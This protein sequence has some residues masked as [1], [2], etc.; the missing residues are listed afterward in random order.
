MEKPENGRRKTVS[1]RLKYEELNYNRSNNKALC[2]RKNPH[3]SF[4][5]PKNSRSGANNGRR[6]AISRQK[7]SRLRDSNSPN[8]QQGSERQSKRNVFPTEV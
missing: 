2:K 3:S 7:I 4:L 8:S 1:Q 5:L 6:T